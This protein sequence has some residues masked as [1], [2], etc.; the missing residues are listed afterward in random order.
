[1][2]HAY[3]A[4]SLLSDQ[5]DA[6]EGALWTALRALEEKVALNR[7]MAQKSRQ[8]DQIIS[9]RHFEENAREMERHA[10]I[11]RQVLRE[12]EQMKIE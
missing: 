2:G 9:V 10:D 7:R 6:V 5:S 1:V 11:I 4:K 12:G 3:S 8:H